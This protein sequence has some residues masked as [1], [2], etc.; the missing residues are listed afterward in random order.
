MKTNGTN[1]DPSKSYERLHLFLKKNA[2]IKYSKIFQGTSGDEK[3][4]TFLTSLLRLT[5]ELF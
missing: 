5:K 4:L 2:T 3:E 1:V